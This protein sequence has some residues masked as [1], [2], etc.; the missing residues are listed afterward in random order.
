MIGKG[1]GA[2]LPTI[3]DFCK[4]LFTY[5]PL[6]QETLAS[7][8]DHAGIPYNPTALTIYKEK[9]GIPISHEEITPTPLEVFTKLESEVPEAHNVETFYEFAWNQFGQRYPTL[10]ESLIHL[11]IQLELFPP[12]TNIFHEN[13]VG[14]KKMVIG[15]LVCEEMNTD[16]V[17]LNLNY[18]VCFDLAVKQWFGKHTYAP[19]RKHGEIRIYKPH[20]SL[21][22]FTNRLRHL[23]TFF[24][25]EDTLGTLIYPDP[26]GGEWNGRSGIIPPRL[27]K[28]YSQHPIAK[29]ILGD[30][31][32]YEPS[33]VTFW[34]VGLTSSDIDL[35]EIYRKACTSAK[36]IEFVNPSLYALKRAEGLLKHDLEHYKDV[37]AWKNRINR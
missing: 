35:L 6:V 28:D 17:I 15:Q 29:A 9:P 8:L 3:A 23:F 11:T 36:K 22:L 19:N 30:I 24:D 21:N 16:D 1:L 27:R 33:I 14:Y 25:P 32:S 13:G 10:W 34:G 20:G 37:E 5:Q 4:K 12:F 26:K 31:Y 2:K 7:Y 18:D